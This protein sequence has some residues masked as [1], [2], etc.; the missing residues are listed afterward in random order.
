MEIT[1]AWAAQLQPIFRVHEFSQ[2]LS[3]QL[4]SLMQPFNKVMEEASAL[5]TQDLLAGV[6]L[7]RLEQVW[8]RNLPPNWRDLPSWKEVEDTLGIMQETGWC[9]V[10]CP[11]AEVIRQLLEADDS[12]ARIRLLLESKG[13]VIDDLRDCLSSVTRQ[14]VDGHRSAAMAAIEAFA[15]GHIA[16]AQALAASDIS[17]LING[18]LGIRTFGEARR[19]LEGDPIESPLPSFRLQAVLDTV[20]RSLQEYYAHRG[21]PVPAAFNRHATVHSMSPEQFTE[22]NS[23]ASLLLL[24]AFL[25]ELDLLLIEQDD[26]D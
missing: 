20:S 19:S 7:T 15:D 10:W 18:T 21:D 3:Q 22:V 14:E 9:L 23:L 2:Q 25:K 16:A 13:L 12:D 26:R 5:V 17:A 8:R 11:R 4:D 1:A 6:D 24:V